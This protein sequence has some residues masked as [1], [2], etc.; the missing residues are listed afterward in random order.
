[1]GCA[2]AACSLCVCSRRFS[3]ST[4]SDVHCILVV[5]NEVAVHQPTVRPRAVLQ[6]RQL[7]NRD[8]SG[9]R[10]GDAALHRQ[11]QVCAAVHKS[12]MTKVEFPV[13]KGRC[14]HSRRRCVSGRGCRLGGG[15]WRRTWRCGCECGCA[16]SWSSSC[17]PWSWSSCC[18][19]L[20]T[21]VG[22]TT[23][24]RG[25]S[26]TG[27]ATSPHDQRRRPVHAHCCRRANERCGAVVYT[28]CVCMCV[29][30]K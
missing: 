7:H 6:S 26:H 2:R 24:A 18:S 13:F 12:A 20:T 9:G 25:P 3:G 11:S 21:A 5:S 10:L 17:L 8:G 15:Q 16:W 4:P 22:P 23:C 27:T 14:R 29:V 30:E 28:T 1:M 19:A